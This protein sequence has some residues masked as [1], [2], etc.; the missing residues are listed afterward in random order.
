[1]LILLNIKN[2]RQ[3]KQFNWMRFHPI[4]IIL[5]ELKITFFEII[6]RMKFKI[7]LI[8]VMTSTWLDLWLAKLKTSMFHNELKWIKLND[9]EHKWTKM[10]KIFDHLNDNDRKKM[11]LIKF[12][13]YHSTKWSF[14]DT[15]NDT[16]ISV[17]NFFK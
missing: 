17:V 16:K 7:L 13:H 14:I 4:L 15:K 1:M 12:I 9:F 10:N 2:Y 3:T 5:L 8:Q 6:T 11:F